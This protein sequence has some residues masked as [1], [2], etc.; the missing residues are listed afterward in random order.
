MKKIIILVICFL[1]AVSV[2][3]DRVK[4]IPVIITTNKTATQSVR[5]SEPVSVYY[6]ETATPSWLIATQTAS[7]TTDLGG[8]Q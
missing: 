4:V 5:L 1:F 6:E 8:N 2:Y 7:L 3:A